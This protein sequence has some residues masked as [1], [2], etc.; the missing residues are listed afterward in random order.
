MAALTCLCLATVIGQHFYIESAMGAGVDQS[1]R[2]AVDTALNWSIGVYV[3]CS[4]AGLFAAYLCSR[5]IADPYV[6]TVVRMEALADGDLDSPV[7]FTDYKDCVGRMTKAMAVFA[8]NAKRVETST[9]AEQEVVGAL[10]AALGRLAE[11][12]LSQDISQPFPPEYEQL[13]S[14]FNRA[15]GGLR[16]AIAQVVETAMQIRVSADEIRHASEDLAGRTEQQAGSIEQST[17]A[18][19][20]VNTGVHENAGSAKDASETVRRVHGE[21]SEGGAVVKRAVEAMSAIHQ[22]SQEISQIVGV[23]DGIAFQTNLLALNAGVEAARAGEAGKGFA[24][25]ATEVRA[26]A[27]RSADAAQEIKTLISTSTGQVDAG[28]ELVAKTGEALKHIVDRIATVETSVLDISTKASQQAENL[29]DVNAAIGSIERNTQQNAAM[30]E[31]TAASAHGLSE[32]GQRLAELVQVFR[33]GHNPGNM[34]APARSVAANAASTP[35][36][37]A[38]RS[39]PRTGHVPAKASPAMPAV[40]G[41]LALAVDDWS[42]F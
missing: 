34:Q 25:V 16:V 2:D 42:E 41:N 4:G 35:A 1:T 5:S 11:N 23:I 32:Q 33:T 28:V 37:I 38:T 29:Q 22:S 8:E 7:R 19:G 10:R 21:A 36:P 12:D 17:V 15:I 27:Q 9:K 18:L 30:V 3:A 26:L 13:R 31:E 39:A 40:S 20:R 14:D 24:V 6:E